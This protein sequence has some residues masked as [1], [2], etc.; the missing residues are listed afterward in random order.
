[1]GDP[2]LDPRAYRVCQKPGETLDRY[3]PLAWLQ[4]SRE[5]YPDFAE[6]ARRCREEL[7]CPYFVAYGRRRRATLLHVEGDPPEELW[8][9]ELGMQYLLLPLQARLDPQLFLDTRVLR[10]WLLAGNAGGVRV[11]NL[12]SYTCS[13]GVAAERGGASEVWNVDFSKNNLAVGERNAER[14]GCARQRFVN[15]EVYPILWQLARKRVPPRRTYLKVQPQPFEL[16]L[17]DPPPLSKGSFGAVNAKDD[18]PSLVAP[19]LEILSPGGTL[20]A[21][22]NLHSVSKEDLQKTVLRTAEKRGKRLELAGWL[23]P[24][25]DFPEP[26]LKIGLFRAG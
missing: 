16:I 1:M 22:N 8:V 11:L 6:I 26:G 9:E 23:D 10:R 2:A 14:N 21:C 5:P 24:D 18:Y 7:G 3:G 12:F 20:V 19:C 17:L 4:C 15:E 25:S 13:L